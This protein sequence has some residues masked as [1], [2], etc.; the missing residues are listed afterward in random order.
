MFET[1]VSYI[2]I[3]HFPLSPSPH[4]S[5]VNWVSCDVTL[6]GSVGGAVDIKCVYF[7]GIEAKTV[8]LTKM[9]FS[10]SVTIIESKLRDQTFTR[11]RLSLY[12][13]SATRFF[14]V[15][16]HNLSREDAGIYSCRILLI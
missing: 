9:N 14:T 1:A 5:A 2:I 4:V 6:E 13:D 10:K 11:G 16:I 15:T 12:H 8:L 7:E 3:T